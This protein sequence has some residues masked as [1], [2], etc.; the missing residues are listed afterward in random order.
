V[1]GA[2][3]GQGKRLIPSSYSIKE[4]LWETGPVFRAE[5]THESSEKFNILLG[6]VGNGS[7]W[8]LTTW[9]D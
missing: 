2:W 4:A 9:R 8:I 3:L 6:L 1:I 7:A 5:V